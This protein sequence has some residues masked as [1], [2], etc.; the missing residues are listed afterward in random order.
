MVKK[1]LKYLLFSILGF[2]LFVLLVLLAPTVW[3]HWITYPQLEKQVNKFQKLRKEP[4][5]L[6]KLNTYRGVLHVHSYLSHDSKGTLYDIIPAAKIDGIDFIFLTDHPH[7]DIDTFPHGYKGY[8]EGVL[9]EPGSEKQ[10]FDTWPLDSTIINWKVD[11]DTIA[12]NIVSRG[13]IIFYAHTEEPHNWANPYYQGMEIYNFHT[14]TKDESLPPQIINFIVNGNKYRQWALREM[15]DEQTSILALWDSLNIKRKIVGFSAVDTHE[16]QN[17]RARYLKDGRV[18]WVGPNANVIDTMEVKFWNRW[19]LH[20][21]DEDGWIFKWMIDTYKSG[22]NYIT[23]YVLADTLSVP[24]LADHLKM[25]HLYTA[26]KSLGDAKGFMYYCMNQDDSI[27]GIL[28]DSIKM[29]QV[30]TL[31]AV[32]PLPGQFRLIHDGKT[33]NVSSDDNY[34][35]TWEELIEKGAYRIEM[36]IKLKE[37]YVPWLYSNPIYI[38]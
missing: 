9:I 21:P 13:G 32:S 31:N 11:K 1:I 18:E 34:Q 33:V 24:S 17:I 10:G 19:L 35:Y 2:I 14:D 20:Q 26:F 7:G 37:K 16:N 15:F 6:T 25:G 38:Y 4:A 30:K 12:K 23:N 8:Y 5:S 22:F 28:G 29:D 36:H 27:G 3:R